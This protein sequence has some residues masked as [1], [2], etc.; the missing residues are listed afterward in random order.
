MIQEFSNPE[1][2]DGVLEL[3]EQLNST[4]ESAASIAAKTGIISVDEAKSIVDRKRFQIFVNPNEPQPENG[5][6]GYFKFKNL[7]CRF[8]DISLDYALLFPIRDH[9]WSATDVCSG[10]I[11]YSE[12]QELI[13]NRE[14]FIIQFIRIEEIRLGSGKQ[15]PESIHLYR[16]ILG[17][18]TFS[19]LRIDEVGNPYYEFLDINQLD[20]ADFP[21]EINH[22][23]TLT[24]KN[25]YAPLTTDNT[26]YCVLFAQLD[27]EYDDKA[28]KVLRWFPAKKGCEADQLLGIESDGGDIFFEMGY[29][30]RHENATL[31]SFMVEH[32]SRLLFGTKT[33]DKITIDGG[34]KIFQTNDL[35]YPVCLYKIKIG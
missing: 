26:C 21:A 3:H 25:F 10:G 8:L 13:K 28:I 27:N 5:F 22:E 7:I 20:V 18:K 4:F 24:G 9:R 34:I 16:A 32:N 29:I 35:K 19:D 33:G 11:T 2:V 17:K 15:I 31:H 23:Y 6:R 14:P 1:F 12:I 30:S